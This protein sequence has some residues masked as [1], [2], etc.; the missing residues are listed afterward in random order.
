MKVPKTEG[1]LLSDLLKGIE[2]GEYRIPR[3][4]RNYVWNINKVVNLIDSLLKGFPIGSL[5]LWETKT[6]LSDIRNL[7]GIV[8]P[9]KNTGKYTSYVIDGQQRLTSLYCALNGLKTETSPTVD[10]SKIVISL[11]ANNDEQIVFKEL[12]KNANPDDFVLLKN[13]YD[14]TA[15]N[16]LHNN[17]RIA[18]YQKLISYMVSSIKID[19][20]ILGL[21]QVIDIFERINL[22]GKKLN[23]FSIIS[24]GSYIPS[25]TENEGFDL[26][27]KYDNLIKG[28]LKA[29]G[30]IKDTTLLQIIAACLI[31]KCNKTS[32]LKE[33]QNDEIDISKNYNKIEKAFLKAVD[34]LRGSNYGVKIK[35]ILPYEA[36]LVPFSYFYY[37]LGNN[38]TTEIQSSYLRDYFWRAVLTNSYVT[39]TDSVLNSDLDKMDLILDN[40]KPNYPAFSFSPNDVLK[41][42]SSYT[43]S[44]FSKGM[45]CLMASNNPKS[46]V[47]D[48]EIVIGSDVVSESYEKQL[49]HFFPKKSP[50]VL[51][52]KDYGKKINH[53]LNIVFMDA[54]TNVQIQDENPSKYVNEFN[55]LYSNFNQILQSH[56]IEID[57]FGINAD[58]FDLFLLSRSKT[59]YKALMKKIIV[60]DGDKIELI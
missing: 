15:L 40:K 37:K 60:N 3:F 23:L 2:S 36:L 34:H 42:D 25:T 19:D 18:Y 43:T 9:S 49:H 20:E 35:A 32:I 28:K 7:G 39:A 44:A 50:A 54:L 24:A 47:P 33:L 57:G 1:V 16:G 53:V 11:V 4:Q 51:S 17:V 38:K 22:G 14:A 58:D 12:P 6:E 59:I 10:C 26:T 29:Y 46:F 41:H 45:L 21:Q 13:L 27:T 55:N 56:F 31:R 8:I 5:I 48:R 30:E 52:N